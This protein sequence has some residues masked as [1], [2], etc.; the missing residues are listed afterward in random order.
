LDGKRA[1]HHEPKGHGKV[2]P[3]QIG[4]YALSHTSPHE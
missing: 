3:R 2:L 4:L 1:Q